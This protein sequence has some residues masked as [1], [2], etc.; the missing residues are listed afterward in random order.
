LEKV[1]EYIP[2]ATKKGIVEEITENVF[3]AMNMV[4]DV[5]DIDKEKDKDKDTYFS[6]KSHNEELLGEEVF[7]AMTEEEEKWRSILLQVVRMTQYSRN[8]YAGFSPRAKFKYM[9]IL[10]KVRGGKKK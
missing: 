10:E 4:L 1:Q 7:Y 9:D 6:F 3:I 2:D 5:V 8:E